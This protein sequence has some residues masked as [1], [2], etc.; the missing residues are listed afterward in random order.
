MKATYFF[1]GSGPYSLISL[2]GNGTVQ[3]NDKVQQ[4]AFRFGC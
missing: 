2:G 4:D 3:R 1:M